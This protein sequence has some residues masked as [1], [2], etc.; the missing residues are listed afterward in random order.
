MLFHLIQIVGSYSVLLKSSQTDI[1]QAKKRTFV[2][3]KTVSEN[4]DV[5]ASSPFPFDISNAAMFNP[6]PSGKKM[7]VV[8]I[9]GDKKDEPFI[10]VAKIVNI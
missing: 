1:Y 10:E 8:R 6:S 3:S 9:E 5:I 4:G 2:T 7:A